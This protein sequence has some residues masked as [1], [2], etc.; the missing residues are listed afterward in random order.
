MC[1][2]GI[3]DMFSENISSLQV[4]TFYGKH[5]IFCFK[6]LLKAFNGEKSFLP[7]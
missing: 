5:E 1:I 7:M 4:N 2:K 3:Q 6:G